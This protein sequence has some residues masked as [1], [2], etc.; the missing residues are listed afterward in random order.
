MWCV[1]IK[2]FFLPLSKHLVNKIIRCTICY[3]EAPGKIMPHVFGIL[4]TF[5]T[6]CKSSFSMYSYFSA[7]FIQYINALQCSTFNTINKLCRHL[8]RVRIFRHSNSYRRQNKQK[9]PLSQTCFLFP[10][11]M[12][13][14]NLEYT[15]IRS[16][17]TNKLYEKHEMKINS[18]RK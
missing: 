10:Y 16:A 7:F 6:F 1:Y 14:K 8:F 15:N 2:I 4:I 17:S 3:R 12:I 9:K 13:K 18:M 5:D 11:K